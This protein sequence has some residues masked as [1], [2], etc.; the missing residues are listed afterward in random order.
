LNLEVT[1]FGR[2]THVA[3]QPTNDPEAGTNEPVRVESEEMRGWSGI[4]RNYCDC[5]LH[6]LSKITLPRLSI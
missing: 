3:C 2:N 5:Y 6:F 1:G 4:Q